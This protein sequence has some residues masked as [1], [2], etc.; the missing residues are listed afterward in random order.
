[1]Y[2]V[3]RLYFLI[4]VFLLGAITHAIDSGLVLAVVIP[5]VICTFMIYDDVT[6]TRAQKK[7]AKDCSL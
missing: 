2:T 3:R 4:V 1:M 5:A 6:F 7:N